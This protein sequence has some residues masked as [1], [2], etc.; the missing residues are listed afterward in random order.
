MKNKTISL[1]GGG[2]IGICCALKLQSQGYKVT[3]IDRNDPASGCSSG[4]A[5]HFATEQIFPMA[6]FS[7]L[8]KLPELLLY[9]QAPLKI[10]TSYILKALP[11]FVRFVMAAKKQT[12]EEGTKALISLNEASMLAYLPLIKMAQAE[13]LIQQKGYVLCFEGNNAFK[14]A[15]QEHKKLLPYGINQQL[16]DENTIKDLE[17]NLSNCHS[18]IYYPDIYH[19]INPLKFAES[20]FNAFILGG[21]SFLKQ[22]VLSVNS[23]S[24]AT[25][26]VSTRETT[27]STDQVI[28]AAGAF[29]KSLVK[30]LGHKIP[31]ETERG[32]H[33]MVNQD[34]LITR[35]VAFAQRRFIMTPLS[36]ATRLA[37]TVEFA[38]LKN[39]ANWNRA[40]V[41]LKQAQHFLK[42]MRN[43]DSN[44][45]SRW[46]GFR[47]SFPDSLPVIDRD[48]HN[49]NLFYAFG[50]HHLGLTQAAITADLIS[51]LIN[52]EKP[53]VDIKPF[54][55]HRF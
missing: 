48:R 40:E 25:I 14:M 44:E 26:N 47:P 9:P 30:N 17:Q 28:I 2:I 23:N 55:I 3:L 51:N 46:M 6:N 10:K 39:K 11:W 32:Y 22:D 1:I 34:K 38:G 35:P 33:L 18:A 24:D 12:F 43:I 53:L 8:K 50:H 7:I 42:P 16:L 19:S 5:G 13:N 52:K 36:H 20:L 49:P 37:G 41:L 31:L 29:S 4:N 21:G 45:C 27:F 54:S 15:Q